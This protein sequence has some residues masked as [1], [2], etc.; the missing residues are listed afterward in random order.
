MDKHRP[1]YAIKPGASG[2]ITLGEDETSNEFVA[3]YLPQAGNYNTTPLIYQGLYYSVLDRGSL[4][5]YDPKTGEVVYQQKRINEEGLASFTASPWA[6]NG[7]IFMV[8]EQ[9]DTYV[10]EA[11]RE[12]KLLGV[13][14]LGEMCMSTPAIAG[15][16]LLIRTIAK[17]YCIER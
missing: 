16:K 15:D 1:V 6:Y 9:G 4:E 11:G 2:D 13:N 12:F 7:K 8:S 14:E 5:C 10:V 17:L 3:W